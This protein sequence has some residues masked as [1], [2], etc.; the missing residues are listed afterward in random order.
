M[1]N[2]TKRHQ[3]ISSYKCFENYKEIVSQQ[4]STD[5]SIYKAKTKKKNNFNTLDSVVRN[6]DLI[7]RKFTRGIW[8]VYVFIFL[9]ISARTTE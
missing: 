8:Y 4:L 1:C 9:C 3:I 6:L 7:L 2:I 5:R